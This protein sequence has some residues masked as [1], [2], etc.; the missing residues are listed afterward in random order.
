MHLKFIVATAKDAS[1]IAALRTKVAE[2]LTLA[3]GQGHWS[4][5]VSERSVLNAIRTSKVFV[6]RECMNIVATL[7]LTTK[8]PWAIDESYFTFCKRPLYLLDMVVEPGRQR[9]GLGRRCL[10]EAKRI[11]VEWPADAIHLDAYDV[12][13]GA[14]GFYVRCGYREVARVSYRNTPLVYCE[15]ML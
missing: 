15:L 14:G 13:G 1:E 6:V 12:P 4:S 10:L 5:A 3:Q 8:K 7:R 2:H 9:R 11:A